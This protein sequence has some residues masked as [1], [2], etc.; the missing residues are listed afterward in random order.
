MSELTEIIV[1]LNRVVANQ[2]CSSAFC[3]IDAICTL[4]C[5][6]FSY[7][8]ALALNNACIITTNKIPIGRD[9][10]AGSWIYVAIMFPVA[11]FLIWL[12]M[13]K[14]KPSLKRRFYKK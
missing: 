14:I 9:N 12:I 3:V 7:V 1:L 11:I 5:G 6:A 2:E 4:F 8:I 13:G 10:M